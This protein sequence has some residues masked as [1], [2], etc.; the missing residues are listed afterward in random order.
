MANSFVVD[1]R[2]A[3]GGLAFIW[4][5][6]VNV[7]LLSYSQNHISLSVNTNMVNQTWTLTGFYGDHVTGRRKLSWALLRALQPADDHPWL[8]LGDYNEILSNGE[9]VGG[10]LRPLSQM[11][12][13]RIALLD[14]GLH[15]LGF[16]GD[17]FTWCNNR[18]G[19]QFTK[20]RLDRACANSPWQL[21]FGNYSVTS[22]AASCSDHNPLVV[23]ILTLE[24]LDYRVEKPFRYEV[25]WELQEEC[26][27]VIEESWNRNS[28]KSNKLQVASENLMRSRE[29]NL[30][31]EIQAA[32][33]EINQLLEEEDTHWR[34]RAKQK[35]LLEGDRNTRFFHQC[36][37][38]RRKKNTIC[39]V[40]DESGVVASTPE[41]VSEK[42]NCFFKNLFSTS[43][44]Q[45]LSESLQHLKP[46]VTEEMNTKLKRNFTQQEVEEAIFNM[47]PFSSPGPDRF[48]PAFYQNH[49]SLVGKE[50]SEAALYILNS[51]GKVDSIN[52]TQIVLIPK[53]ENPLTVSDYR[54]IS[55]C[56]VIYKMVSKAI[57][58][59]LKSILPDIISSTQSAFVP[60]R[61]ISDNLIVAFEALHTMHSRL[62]GKEGL[63][64][65]KLDMSKAYDRIEWQFL[66]EVMLKM[67]FATEWVQL[68]MN[69][70]ETVSY[71]IILNGSPQEVFIPTRGIRQGDPLSPYLFILCA[72]VLTSLL[73]NAERTKAITGIQI[74][75]RRVTINHL[76]FADDS[77]LFCKANSL[78]WSRM[79]HVLSTYE[80]ASGQRLNKDK[81]AI[82]FSRNTSQENKDL[83]LSTTGVHSAQSYERYLGLPALMG[84]SRT[85]SFKSI[86]DKIRMKINSLKVRLF[87]QAG[88]EIFIK[89]VLQAMPTYSMAVFNLP[90]SLLKEI[91]K[92]LSNFWWGQVEQERK[93]HWT[94]WKNMGRAKA[95]GGMGFREL[96]SFNLAM[97]AKQTWRLIHYPQALVSEVLKAKYFPHGQF[98]NAKLEHKPS[99]FWRSIMAARDMIVKGTRW[100]VGNGATINI[101]QDK[102]IPRPTTFR[103]QATCPS[104]SIGDKVSSLIDQNSR[105]WNSKLVNQ[106]FPQEEAEI[107]QQIPLSPSN[108]EDKLIW[109][110][111]PQGIYS[112]KSAYH[113]LREMEALE[114]GQG[115]NSSHRDQFWKRLWK[116][117]ITPT[118]KNFMWRV[119]NEALPTNF[120]LFKRKILDKPLCPICWQ[121][122]ETILHALWS[123]P[124][125]QDVWHNYSRKIQKL[126]SQWHSI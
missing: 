67:G 121:E 1:S 20:E 52:D 9:K 21:L 6:Y 3:S 17:Q 122:D 95:I 119:C 27:K 5:D 75:R 123:C 101:L 104:I 65:L 44:P 4:N 64:A 31:E 58:N 61:L 87:S 103:V 110:G 29:R 85:K 112:V 23:S 57:A 69:C 83:I 37:T 90:G 99:Y 22:T 89:S 28:P 8:C 68:V 82:H 109:L 13:F 19:L 50:V 16:K 35:W 107:I 124:A 49:W 120:N 111:T 100:R 53:K 47:N 106:L 72:E 38:Q 62:G 56:N 76:L 77:L 34:Q 66:K 117:R 55:L 96:H 88:K 15:D 26:K 78:E 36:A 54:P 73:E 46:S 105:Q 114:K 2:G 43:N 91:N 113:M 86:L 79:L 116:L 125:A 42:F 40:A 30:R 63:M 92:L 71:S 51:G 94:S 7:N 41:G 108:C 81:T 33:G 32:R 59:R 18:E 10:A 25:R 12:E 24:Q 84:K 70:V 80:K 11:E 60:G 115:S 48:P 97:L 39:K 74:A 45:G 93:I 102:W 98:L 14:T 126:K 118:A